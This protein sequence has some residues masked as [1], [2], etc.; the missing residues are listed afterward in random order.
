LS[1]DS[2]IG[3]DAADANGNTLLSEAAV[4][5]QAQA[6]VALRSRGQLTAACNRF[7]QRGSSDKGLEVRSEEVPA[8]L[9]FGHATA[10]CPVF[11]RERCEPQ[12]PRRVPTHASL[13]RCLRVRRTRPSIEGPALPVTA[14]WEVL[15]WDSACPWLNTVPKHLGP[16]RAFVAPPAAAHPQ[17]SAARGMYVRSRF[18]CGLVRSQK[19]DCIK[20]LLEVRTSVASPVG[21]ALCMRSCTAAAEPVRSIS[22]GLGLSRMAAPEGRRR[23]TAHGQGREHPRGDLLGQGGKGAA[24]EVQPKPRAAHRE[25]LLGVAS[26]LGRLRRFSV[27]GWMG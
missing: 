20:S 1:T 2:A 27:S 21:A 8:H 3:V 26:R 9:P 17:C 19:I 25:R 14:F 10:A 4:G 16:L 5:G 22:P 7:Q 24:R 15:R 6:R 23:P 11:A 13:A 18:E 12:Q